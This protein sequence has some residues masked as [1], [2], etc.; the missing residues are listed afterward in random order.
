[1]QFTVLLT[2][3]HLKGLKFSLIPTINGVN[4]AW[5]D[6]EDKPDRRL[7]VVDLRPIA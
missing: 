2:K 4:L 1:M 6:L 5:A 7:D 3:V